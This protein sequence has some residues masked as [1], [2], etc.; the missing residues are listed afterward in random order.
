[1]HVFVTVVGVL[2]FTMHNAGWYM[3]VFALARQCESRIGTRYLSDLSV[4]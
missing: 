2:E 3:Y 4:T 1:M